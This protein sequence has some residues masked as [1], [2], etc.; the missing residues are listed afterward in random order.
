MQIILVREQGTSCPTYIIIPHKLMQTQSTRRGQEILFARL[1]QNSFAFLAQVIGQ[2]KQQSTTFDTKSGISISANLREAFQSVPLLQSTYNQA[3]IL[4]DTATLL[5]PEEEFHEEDIDLMFAHALSGHEHETK[6]CVTLPGLHAVVVFSIAKD[7]ITIL[8]DHFSN[9]QI[10]PLCHPV[11]Q[12]VS[13]QSDYIGRQRLNAYFHDG[14]VD[15]FCISKNR[16]KFCNTFGATYEHDALYYLLNTFTQLGFQ[17]SRDEFV[18]MGD[19]PHKKWIVEN[20]KH[21][22]SQVTEPD[23]PAS[24]PDANHSYPYDL[25]LLSTQQIMP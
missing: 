6:K 22:V 19:T 15:I 13:R 2:D 17:A 8:S 18:I 14:K 5:V 1:S 4:V 9:Y 3:V 16:F 11:W 21:Y 25:T 10:L 7:I 12:H 20:L 24:A 23:I